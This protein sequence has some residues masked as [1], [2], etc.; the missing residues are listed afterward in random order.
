VQRGRFLSPAGGTYCDTTNRE[1]PR[2]NGTRAI[3]FI[4]PAYRLRGEVEPIGGSF[5]VLPEVWLNPAT[6]M[7]VGVGARNVLWLEP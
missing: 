1:N 5:W 6:P 7:S 3:F 2:A 4:L